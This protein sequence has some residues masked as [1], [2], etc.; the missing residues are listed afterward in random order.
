M[1]RTL[2]SR[3]IYFTTL[4]TRAQSQ[5]P[6]KKRRSIRAKATTASRPKLPFSDPISKSSRTTPTDETPFGPSKRDKKAIKHSSFIS[7]IEKSSSTKKRRRPNKKLVA[8]LVSLADA[9]PDLDDEAGGDGGD[10]EVVIGQAKIQRKSL[11][12]RPGA[13]KRKEKLETMERE[14]FNANLVQMSGGMGVADRWA[15]LKNHVRSTV[16][17]KAEFAAKK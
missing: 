5:A 13:M 12:S 14:R 3:K 6:S 8:N 17:Q 16:E 4:L 2:F 15:A 10:S 11:K 7:K 9:L 1:V